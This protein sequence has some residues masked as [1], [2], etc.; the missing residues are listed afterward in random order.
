MQTGAA[1][2]G[3][4]CFENVQALDREFAEL[5]HKSGSL[6]FA[7]GLGLEA[8]ARGSGH[9]DLGF[10]SIEAY[11]V[12]RCERHATWVRQ[13]RCLVRRV[14]ELPRLRAA[15]ISGQVS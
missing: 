2:A 15:L 3:D 14:S 9:E 8:L 12:E 10:A 11:G 5:A 1:L 6:R 7:L 13:S 4:A